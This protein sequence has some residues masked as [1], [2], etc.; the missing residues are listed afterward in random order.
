MLGTLDKMDCVTLASMGLGESGAPVEG[1]DVVAVGSEVVEVGAE[2]V[3]IVF[4]VVDAVVGAVVVVVVVG[5]VS[6]VVLM[7]VGF[8]GLATGSC[9]T[10][11]DFLLAFFWL[12][13]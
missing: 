9:F 5:V 8:D 6:V 4:A 11:L 12:R 7:V 13:A 10:A 3:A 2:V 1:S